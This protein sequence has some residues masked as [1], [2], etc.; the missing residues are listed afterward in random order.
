[1]EESK[2]ID[3][4]L[5]LIDRDEEAQRLMTIIVRDAHNRNKS[6]YHEISCRYVNNDTERLLKILEEYIERD[7]D[8]F[9]S[10]DAK[11]LSDRINY[12]QLLLNA[13]DRQGNVTIGSLSRLLAIYLLSERTPR[14]DE[15]VDYIDSFEIAEKYL[16][17]INKDGLIDLSNPRIT[18]KNHA[19]Q[20]DKNICLY[21]HQFMR[22]K[23]GGN[24]AGI[25]PLLRTALNKGYKVCGRIDPLR[26]SS[27]E[28]YSE[29]VECDHWHGARF[30]AAILNSKDKGEFW[31]VHGSDETKKEVQALGLAYPVSQTHFRTSMMDDNLRQFSIEEYVPRET[32]YG[33]RSSNFG[34]KYHIQK[35]AHFVYDQERKIVEHIDCAVRIFTVDEYVHIFDKVLCG[36]DPGRQIGRRRKLFKISGEIDLDFTKSLLYE[37]FMYNPHIME[38]FCGKSFDEVIDF[39]RN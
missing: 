25:P 2:N 19:L 32:S 9:S 31:T 10:P 21:L 13:K 39:I 11:S 28:D 33:V 8:I 4:I 26:V 37:Y 20:I 36:K 12:Q 16:L 6:L 17:T 35:F 15:Y 38:Y 23:F 29:I 1:M 27:M 14:I 7:R 22:R 3:N 24:F 34:K 18:I 5:E 30:D